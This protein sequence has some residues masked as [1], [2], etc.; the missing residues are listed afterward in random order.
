MSPRTALVTGANR[1][2]GLAVTGELARAGYLVY[3]ACREP[4]AAHDMATRLCH[5]VRPVVMDVADPASVAAARAA[6][7]PVDILVSNAGVLLDADADPVSASLD[8]V[9]QTLE[10]NAIGAW[11]VAQA[12]LPGMVRA[13]WGRVVMISSGTASLSRGVHPGTPGYTVSK[14]ALNA[15]TVMLATAV[16][17][18]G[19][20]VNAVNPGRVR[21]RMMPDATVSPKDVAGDV[22]WAAT[23][24]DDGPTGS[25]LR[26]RAVVPW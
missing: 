18:T 23:L 6:T 2:I 20:L 25:F 19:V 17:G 26:G 4:V 16:G 11:R 24:P 22:V 1:G 15:L 3:A 9:R 5:D 10:V 14:A 12:Y 7:G 8:L 21:T 13:G